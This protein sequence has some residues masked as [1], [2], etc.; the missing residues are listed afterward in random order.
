VANREREVI[1]GRWSQVVLQ[2]WAW[3][4]DSLSRGL[5]GIYDER[6]MLLAD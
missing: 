1:E 2:H 6:G 5:L 3:Q 4:A